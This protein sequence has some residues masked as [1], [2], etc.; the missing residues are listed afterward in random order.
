[1]ISQYLN[2]GI[3]RLPDS[4]CGSSNSYWAT[5]CPRWRTI[6]ITYMWKGNIV[7]SLATAWRIE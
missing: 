7:Q 2:L 6:T 3:L 5:P 1:M 4:I